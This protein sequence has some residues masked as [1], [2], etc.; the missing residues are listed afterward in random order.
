MVNINIITIFPEQVKGFIDIGMLNQAVLKGTVEYNVVDIRDF[1]ENR[2]RKVDD[3]PYGGGP[4]MVMSAPSVIRAVESLSQ[5]GIKILLAPNG[6]EF[7]QSNA[8]DISGKDI[9]LIC[10]RYT[11]IDYRVRKHVD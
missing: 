9:T 10:G 5:P 1:S 3:E 8:E 2:H 4:G 7:T 6:R 11:G